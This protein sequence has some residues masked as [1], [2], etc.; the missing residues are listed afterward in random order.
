MKPRIIWAQCG[1]N[2]ILPTAAEPSSILD[3]VLSLASLSLGALGACTNFVIMATTTKT[4]IG[5]SMVAGFVHTILA[6]YF[7]ALEYGAEAASRVLPRLLLSES[8]NVELTVD[9]MR[10]NQSKTELTQST[11]L[12]R[13]GHIQRSTNV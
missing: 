7:C 10:G 2:A 11:S 1:I 8:K 3:V 13:T 4:S 6:E 5:P 12:R 9:A